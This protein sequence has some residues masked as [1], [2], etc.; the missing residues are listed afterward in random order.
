MTKLKKAL[1]TYGLT[2]VVIG[3]C[4]GSGIFL[5]P[6]SIAKEL[7]SPFLILLVWAIGGVIA[8]SGALTYAEL[9]SRFPGAGG[10]YLFIRK[11]YGDLWG[12]LYGWAV[13]T[14]VTTGAI[15][16]LALAFARYVSYLIPLDDW[17]VKLLAIAG[18]ITLTIVNIF[19]VKFGDFLSSSFT[20][21][22]L[23]GILVV[24][25]IGLWFGSAQ[26]NPIEFSFELPAS[27]ASG[28]MSIFTAI[29]LGLIGVVFSYGG[30]HHAA[31]LSA[32]AHN[33]SRTVPKAM[34]I[35]ALTVSVVYILTNM[36]YLYLLPMPEII[37]SSSLAADAV[38]TIFKS[39]GIFVALLIA[40]STLGTVGI[41]TMSAPRLYF[42]MA[43]DG[44][45]FRQIAHIHPRYGTPVNAILLQSAWSIVLLLFWGTFTKLVTFTVFA[46]WI[47]LSIAAASLFVF[48]SRD[49]DAKPAYKIKSFPLPPLIFIAICSFII[50]NTLINEYQEA[51]TGLAFLA[52]GIPVFYFF[53]KI[54]S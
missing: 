43:K 33:A 30:F 3:S 16:A 6:S 14:I 53:K 13:M 22:K 21:A 40:I 49:K 8:I 4:I 19:G 26:L 48:R 50:L 2:M 28:S 18:I 39:G 7:P 1:S 41:Y 51:L 24:V 45:F 10:I 29:G 54:N 11:A 37:G 25:G 34:V 15:A 23:V 5:T 31:F 20:G 12:F 27:E 35:G 32:E 36:G 52:V 47:F 42:A 17:G 44:F 46:E 9:A 38:T